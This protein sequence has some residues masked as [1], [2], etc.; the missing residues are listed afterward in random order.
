M[1]TSRQQ[2]RQSQSGHALL[3]LAISAGVMVACLAGTVQFGYTFYIYNELV[4]AVGNG[5]RYAAMRTY[6]AATPRDI[7]TGKTAIRN[8][9]AYG[10]ARPELN[11]IPQVA[12]LRPEDV[13]VDWVMDES[14]K[15]A[16]V[17]VAIADYTVDAAF[18]VFR[19]TGRPAVEYPFVGRFAPGETE[20]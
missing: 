17:N 16:Y 5:G 11:A 6:R 8:M 20:P 7:E 4:T 9:V 19:F 1:K 10:D 3:E 15:P 14:G 12:N 18:G 13:Q 2:H